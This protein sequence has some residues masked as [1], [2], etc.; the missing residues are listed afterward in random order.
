MDIGLQGMIFSSVL[1]TL[2]F[3]SLRVTLFCVPIPARGMSAKCP[4]LHSDLGAKVTKQ[5]GTP[6]AAHT[7]LTTLV[8]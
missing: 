6:A 2:F 7:L 8:V 4:L 3:A 1:A 5:K